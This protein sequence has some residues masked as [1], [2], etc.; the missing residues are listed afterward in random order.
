MTS[1]DPG[2]CRAQ[3]EDKLLPHRGEQSGAGP[4]P[5]VLSSARPGTDL[6]GLHRRSQNPWGL[7]RAQG[8]EKKE[9]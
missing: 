3:P 4:W 9:A 2:P 7:G 1:S 8:L 6:S 5:G